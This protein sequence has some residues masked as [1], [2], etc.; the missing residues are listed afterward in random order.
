MHS[1]CDHCKT[2]A[3]TLETLAEMLNEEEDSLVKIAKVDCTQEVA[4]CSEHDITGYP[5]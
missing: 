1:R 3:P 5:T 2:L 4:I